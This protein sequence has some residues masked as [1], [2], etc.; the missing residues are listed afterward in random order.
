MEG[1]QGRQKNTFIICVYVRLPR[2]LLIMVMFIIFLVSSNILVIYKNVHRPHLARYSDSDFY[3]SNRTVQK[4]I[5]NGITMHV[6]LHL[7]R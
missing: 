6:Q 4:V 3:C 2:Y 7:A 1:T 5:N